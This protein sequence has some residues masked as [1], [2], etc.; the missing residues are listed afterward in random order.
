MQVTLN[1]KA[2]PSISCAGPKTSVPPQTRPGHPRPQPDHGRG[3]LVGLVGRNGAG[4]PRSSRSWPAFC[5]PMKAKSWTRARKAHTRFDNWSAT[6][7]NRCAGRASAPPRDAPELAVMDGGRLDL[8]EGAIRLV[9]FRVA[10]SDGRPEPRD[11]AAPHVGLCHARK[12]TSCCS[13][14]PTTDLTP[15]LPVASRAS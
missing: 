13:M 11:A 8:V 2:S 6:C 1:S 15:P 10:P 9:G 14:S 3:E 12:R 4:N 5:Q 7:L